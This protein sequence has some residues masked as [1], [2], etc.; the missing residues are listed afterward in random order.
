MN[1]KFNKFDNKTT[2]KMRYIVDDKFFRK[3]KIKE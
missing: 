2:F 3:S 1:E